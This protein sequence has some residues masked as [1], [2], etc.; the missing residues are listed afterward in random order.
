[1]VNT[2]IIVN[3]EGFWH[4]HF[5]E[6][7]DVHHV[8][9]QTSKWMLHDD[10]LFVY[11]DGKRIRVDSIF[12]RIGAIQPYQYHREVLEIIRLSGIPCI[13]TPNVMLDDLNRW[14]ML[15]RLKSLDIPVV[16]F[17]AT[18][19]AL[20]ANQIQIQIPSVI[21]VGSYHA[22]YGKMRINSLE[23][24]QDM[25]DFVFATDGYFTVEPF[26]DY[27][28]DIRCLAVGNQIWSLA[29]NG[30]RWKANSGVVETRLISAPEILYD[31][32][33]RVVDALN[34]DI[35]ALDILESEEGEYIVL[36]SN[37]V[38]GLSGF[39]DSAVQAVV[40]RV[41]MKLSRT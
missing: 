25:T 29:R 6:D 9:L 40:E 1:M 19:G 17:T 16:P 13:N 12:W 36:E 27:K 31:Y 5:V 22:G 23:Q 30:S 11:D 35:I 34:A 39:P 14:S 7:F 28:R 2:L 41:K 21:K 20:L 26:I 24:W 38:P 18:I 33:K 8:R 4:D 3:G 32:T 10:K 15:N 37:S